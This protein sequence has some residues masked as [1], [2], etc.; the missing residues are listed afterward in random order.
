MP[1]GINERQRQRFL[2]LGE[3]QAKAVI[4]ALQD[5]GIEPALMNPA[6]LEAVG[7]WATGWAETLGIPRDEVDARL[8][9]E[10]A[11]RL[12]LRQPRCKPA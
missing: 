11:T 10:L 8:A 6:A 12:Q 7:A 5:E 4:D 1:E 3:E 2:M 9:Q